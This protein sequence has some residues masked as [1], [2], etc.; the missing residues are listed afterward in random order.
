MGYYVLMSDSS[1]APHQEDLESIQGMFRTIICRL[2]L[3]EKRLDELIYP[4]E[5]QFS[6]G[7]I[8]HVEKQDREIKAGHVLSYS[9]AD[10]LFSSFDE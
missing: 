5:E 9:D 3:I 2:D 8:R 7:F 10:E 1:L 4:P 6:A